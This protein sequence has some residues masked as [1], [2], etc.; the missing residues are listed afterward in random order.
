[1]LPDLRV[2]GVL[3]RSL[4]L[5]PLQSSARIQ[6]RT[7]FTTFVC[8][9]LQFHYPNQR[10]ILPM[11]SRPLRIVDLSRPLDRPL[12]PTPLELHLIRHASFA[13]YAI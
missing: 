8:P 1:V 12:R 9:F 7:N 4:A 5:A 3:S 13:P 10:R 2:P 6:A 11:K